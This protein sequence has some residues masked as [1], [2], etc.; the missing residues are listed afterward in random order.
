MKKSTSTMQEDYGPLRIIIPYSREWKKNHMS[1]SFRKAI[2]NGRD[3][4]R[5]QNS[6]VIHF[7]REVM[8]KRDRQGRSLNCTEEPRTRPRKYDT[9]RKHRGKNENPRECAAT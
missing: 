4:S 3:G 5:Q 9:E 8:K 1:K 7:K 2:K 6:K